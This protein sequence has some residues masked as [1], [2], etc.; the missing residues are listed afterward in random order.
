MASD[1]HEP[2]ISAICDEARGWVAEAAAVSAARGQ[3]IRSAS[4]ATMA[5]RRR[6]VQ[7]RRGNQVLWHV[8]TLR[9]AD[10][11]NL[12]AIA[13]NACMPVLTSE[14]KR[15]LDRLPTE[16]A[17]ATDDLRA[18]TGFGRLLL[19]GETR[20]LAPRWHDPDHPVMLGALVPDEAG[21]P[22]RAAASVF[23]DRYLEEALEDAFARCAELTGRNH[24]PLSAHRLDD[25]RLI[26]VAMGS[27]VETAEAVADHMRAAH[28]QKVGVLGIRCLSPFPGAELARKANYPDEFVAELSDF[29][30][31]YNAENAQVMESRSGPH[32]RT[33]RTNDIDDIVA[34]VDEYG[35][36]LI[37]NLLVA[38]GYAFAPRKEE[39][40]ASDT[41]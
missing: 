16:V 41:D 2:S 20:R 19:F 14:V 31:K 13:T 24:A 33:I 29:L 32:R 12:R 17:Q 10:V 4:E 21:G 25:A 26:L 38:Y 30:F 39:S 28:R 40:E 36:P 27:A 3:V 15:E 22:G 6:I 8:L 37:C 7:A 1:D 9:M 34:L 35:A 23:L 5:L 11:E 18:V